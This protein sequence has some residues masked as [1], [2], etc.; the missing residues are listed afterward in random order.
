MID[1]IAFTFEIEIGGDELTHWDKAIAEKSDGRFNIVYRLNV[2]L[3]NNA[4]ILCTYYPRNFQGKPQLI[5]E[6]SLPKL[7][8]GIITQYSSIS[9]RQFNVQMKS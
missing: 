5:I 2:V 8:L 1:T 9:K 7:V 4:T 6:F 3:K